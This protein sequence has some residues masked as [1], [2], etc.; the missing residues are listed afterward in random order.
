[1]VKRS[2]AVL[3]LAGILLV[4]S[5]VSVAGATEAEG[6]EYVEYE[7]IVE[8][9]TDAGAEFLPAEYDIPGFFD[10]IIIPLVGV[11]VLVT[12]GL[13]GYYLIAQPRFAREAE[14]RSKR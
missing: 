2:L 4:G 14:E 10:W 6:G 1:M 8:N 7:Q 13:L 9:S 3:M 5:L 12:A 11:G